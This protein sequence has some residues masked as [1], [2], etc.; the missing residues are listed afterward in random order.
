MHAWRALRAA[1][2]HA[3]GQPFYGTHNT[4][5]THIIQ[6]QSLTLLRKTLVG[7]ATECRLQSTCYASCSKPFG[8]QDQ[9]MSEQALFWLGLILCAG[10]RPPSFDML[11]TGIH[12]YLRS[13][14]TSS[15]C[16]NTANPRGN[17]IIIHFVRG[18]NSNSKHQNKPTRSATLMCSGANARGSNTL[19][20]NNR[21]RALNKMIYYCWGAVA[22][23]LCAPKHCCRCCL[24]VT[25]Y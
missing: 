18:G 7:Q 25:C 20:K 12:T 24:S 6:L 23:A 19:Q 4:T 9:H 11:Q 22:V 13:A 17:V 3:P 10:T 2:L 8:S 14:T 1:T 16:P 21:Q 5:A 15:P